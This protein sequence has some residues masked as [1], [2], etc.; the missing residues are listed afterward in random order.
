MLTRTADAQYRKNAKPLIE[1][2]KM[3]GKQSSDT[4]FHARNFLDCVK[5]RQKCTCDIEIGHRSTSATLLANVALKTKSYLEWDAKAERFTNNAA[6]N[7]LH[8]YTYRA[9]YK[10]PT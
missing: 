9:P 1:P 3:A 6:A 2:V 10:L 5:S 4:A 8:S 7:K